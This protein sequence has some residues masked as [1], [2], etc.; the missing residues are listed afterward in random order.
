M[1]ASHGIVNGPH[2]NIYISLS[3]ADDGTKTEIFPQHMQFP[4]IIREIAQTRHE[5]ETEKYMKMLEQPAPIDPN[6]ALQR[7]LLLRMP[8]QSRNK[9]LAQQNLPPM[10]K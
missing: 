4:D 1:C 2:P 6:D 9:L 8:T 10:F 3:L 5:F 7:Y